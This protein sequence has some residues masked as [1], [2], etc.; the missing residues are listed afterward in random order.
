MFYVQEQVHKL[1]RL[2]MPLSWD[3]YLSAVKMII[4]NEY[5][6]LMALMDSVLF[7]AWLFHGNRVINLQR[8][9]QFLAYSQAVIIPAV[10]GVSLKGCRIQFPAG[11]SDAGRANHS[12]N[13][14][15]YPMQPSVSIT[16]T[17][18]NVFRQI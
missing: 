8:W 10:S 5:A 11:T 3:L 2:I 7:S 6:I 15:I 18:P 16:L 4:M 1:I 14:W 13:V 9:V 12:A 17:Q